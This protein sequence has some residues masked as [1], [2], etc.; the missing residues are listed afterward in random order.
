M[1]QFTDKSDKETVK[2]ESKNLKP[3][4]GC[5]LDL[6]QEVRRA[7]QSLSSAFK[8]FQDDKK[9]VAMLYPAR[10]VDMS[11]YKTLKEA[12]IADFLSSEK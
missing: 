7:R 4:F 8:S 9:D 11:T 3:P 1:V 2:K 6:P 10:I 5:S 12:D